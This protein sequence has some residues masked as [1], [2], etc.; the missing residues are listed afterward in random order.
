MCVSPWL[1][2]VPRTP[3]SS[4]TMI[5]DSGELKSSWNC[6]IDSSRLTTAMPM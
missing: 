5:S 6:F 1:M 2:K 3:F 4:L